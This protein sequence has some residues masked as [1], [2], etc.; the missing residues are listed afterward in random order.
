M[1]NFL[2]VVI[3]VLAVGLGY[4]LLDRAGYLK[5]KIQVVASNPE[6]TAKTTPAAT[7]ETV[8]DT[9]PAATPAA[10]PEAILAPTAE[11]ATAAPAETTS[12]AS[13]EA[14]PAAAP[15]ETPAAAPAETP[16]TAT[17]T[18]PT[19]AAST[20]T[21]AAPAVDL[22]A[23]EARYLP[24]QVK[25]IKAQPFS[26]MLGGKAIG[27][28]VAPAGVMVKLLGVQG[29][30]IQVLLGPNALKWIAAEDTDISERITNI[31]ALGGDGLC[32]REPPAAASTPWVSKLEHNSSTHP[33]PHS[34]PTPRTQ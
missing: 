5:F 23:V 16:A 6:S 13:S 29:V 33:K 26:I 34:A 21:P 18:A 14:I 32:P 1:K 17:T 9:T 12:P 19:E 4:Q 30:Q 25:L 11:A 7:A 15:A 22:S 20:S 8:A 2:T 3:F 24:K 27:S 28:G 10:T 31:K